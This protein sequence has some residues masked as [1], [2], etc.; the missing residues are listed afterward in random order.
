MNKLQRFFLIF[1]SML[2][3]FSPIAAASIAKNRS[4]C[5]GSLLDEPTSQGR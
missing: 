5:H 4:D 3:P 1:I 2:L